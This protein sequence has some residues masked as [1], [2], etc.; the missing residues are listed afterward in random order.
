[1]LE[2]LNPQEDDCVLDVG[3]G[4]G[5]QLI[6]VAERVD[7][8]VGLDVSADM[9]LELRKRLTRANVSLLV[10]DMDDLSDLQI[11]GPFTLAYSVYS[12]Y[13]S[14]DPASVVET[15]ARLLRGAGARF[16]TVNPGVGNNAEW[17]EDLGHICELP[18]AV[19]G[20]PDFGDRVLAPAFG[21]TFR[22]VTRHSYRDRVRFPTV[23][24]VMTYY[25]ACAPYCPLDT[26]DEARRYFAAKLDRE[27]DY[28]ITKCSLGLVGTL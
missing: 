24:A 23:D 1:V 11:G 27:G 26:R 17:F 2:L 7:R 14:R 5:A 16:V 10:G 20:V 18:A 15:V 6:P 9:M 21:N 28:Q 19:R 25:D 4:L 8:I 22:T 3:C 12:L 13:Y